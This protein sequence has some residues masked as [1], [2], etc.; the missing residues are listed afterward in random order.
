MK[1]SFTMVFAVLVTLFFMTPSGAAR[2]QDTGGLFQNLNILNK[3]KPLQSPQYQHGANILKSRVLDSRNRVVGEVNDVVL[4]DKGGIQALNVEFD[5]LRLGDGVFL[6]YQEMRL[7]PASS[8]YIMNIDDEQIETMFPTFLDD[9]ESAA[10]DEDVVSLEKLRGARVVAK[11]GRRLGEVNEVLFSG[12]GSRA[13]SLYID[14]TYKSARG[15]ALAIPFNIAEYQS[16]GRAVEVVISNNDAD[17]ILNFAA[18]R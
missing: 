15:E 14:L 16:K 7:R 8:G 9:I 17:E 2:A 10:G 6:N 11:D 3:S 5:R 12:N 1:R 13:Y 18:E 4:T